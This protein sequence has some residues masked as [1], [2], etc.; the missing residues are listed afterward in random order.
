[1][2]ASKCLARW[3]TAVDTTGSIHLSV[4]ALVNRVLLQWIQEI[5]IG[6]LQ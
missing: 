5:N 2:I 4:Q 6:K 3:L 1:M